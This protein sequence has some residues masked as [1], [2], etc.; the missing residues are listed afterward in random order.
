MTFSRYIQDS[1]MQ[2]HTT[3]PSVSRQP[4]TAAESSPRLSRHLCTCLELFWREELVIGPPHGN[5]SS[6]KATHASPLAP[7]PAATR[8]AYLPE[9]AAR[10]LHPTLIALTYRPSVVAAELKSLKLD[11]LKTSETSWSSIPM[12]GYQAYRSRRYPLRPSTESLRSGAG[13]SIPYLFANA[14]PRILLRP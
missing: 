6:L 3:A 4:P 13:N 1:Y 11:C 12:C 8:Q 10:C 2:A 7:K 5:P 9:S 14:S